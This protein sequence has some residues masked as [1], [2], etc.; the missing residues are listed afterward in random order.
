[1]KLLVTAA[2]GGL[3]LPACQ[4]ATPDTAAAMDTPA[5]EATPARPRFEG[6]YT[7]TDTTC[8]LSIIITRRDTSYFFECPSARARGPVR[9]WYN[10]GDPAPGLTFVG[11]RGDE[12]RDVSCVWED[13]MLVMQNYGNAMNDYLFF[14]GCSGKY[15]TFRRQ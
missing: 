6:T 5:V 15:L 3:L 9:V 2:L 7:V 8:G 10:P 14:P 1:M 11:L 12:T 13:N 4:P